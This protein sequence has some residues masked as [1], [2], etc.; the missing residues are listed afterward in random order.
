VISF[1]ARL[2]ALP[3]VP[4]ATRLR[5]DL[6][7]T[8]LKPIAQRQWLCITLLGLISFAGSATVGWLVGIPEP[9]FTDEFSYLLAADT[10]SHG[11]LTNPT[12][13][14]WIHFE[15]LHI[16]QQ[17]SYMSKYPPAQGLILAA[18]QKIAGH[19]IF[20]VWLSFGIMC[21]ALTWMLCAWIPRRWAVFG[22]LLAII[23]PKLGIAGYWAQSY[24][25]GAIAAT[26]G[27]LLLGGVRRLTR[28]TRL[29]DSL[30]TAFGLALLAN[31]R[32]YEG[33]LIA[34]PAGV[35]LLAHVVTQRGPRLWNSACR[36]VAP[37]GVVLALTVSAMGYYNFRVTGNPLRLPYQVHEET[38][39][40]A[41]LFL[42]Q[43][44]A[45]KPVYRHVD[46]RDYHTTYV[47]E[48]YQAQLSIPGFL[49]KISSLFWS[50]ILQFLN[51]FLVPLLGTFTLLS[52]WTLRNDWA[53][54]ALVLYAVLI[55][56]SLLEVHWAIHYLAPIFALNYFFIVI[57]MRLWRW[58]Y[59]Q[60]GRLMLG[61]VPSLALAILIA[62]LHTQA[63]QNQSSSW[64]VQRAKLTTQLQQ[65]G[66]RHLILVS[67][68]TEDFRHPVWE[69]NEAN[70]DTARVVWARSMDRT[71][72]CKLLDYFRDRQ[73]WSL[74]IHGEQTR[75]TLK[76]Y[77]AK[78]CT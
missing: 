56:G 36:V 68:A 13:P 17:P 42:W 5:F 23:N 35:Y 1:I 39:A 9:R 76:L 61:L 54:F 11:R 50:S 71:Q 69:Y 6:L 7:L 60:V 41:P 30:F 58:R 8:N 55:C 70:I 2:I 74:E 51:V 15:S 46:I 27:A 32:P 20:G 63:R 22:A 78:L 44:P 33:L 40:V 3:L 48:G 72:N 64:N 26:G 10:F 49:R 34:I 57:A 45:P 66:G 12:H 73:L 59:K 24:W 37:I 77:P 16:I 62:S 31:S 53:R 38:Y 19:P 25:G 4:S 28:R 21:A 52:R 29:S 67:Y 43:A 47:V 14:M 18:G 75:P 65:Q